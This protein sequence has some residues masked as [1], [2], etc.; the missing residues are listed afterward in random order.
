MDQD[1]SE[2]ILS[3]E[4]LYQQVWTTAMRKLAPRYGLSD[5]AL[6]K[7]CKKYKIPRPPAGYWAKIKH[8]HRPKQTPLPACNDTALQTVTIRMHPASGH[9]A[10]HG[11][12]TMDA[13][14]GKERSAFHIAVLHE[15]IDPH[16]LVKKTQKSLL[17][18]RAGYDGLVSPRA[19]DALNIRV[20]P[21]S[22]GRAMRIMD[23]F[24]K[25]CVAHGFTVSA[26]HDHTHKDITVHVN[27]ADVK[28]SFAEKVNRV[29]RALTPKEELNKLRLPSLYDQP[30]HIKF[31][32]GRL[33]MKITTW[34]RRGFRRQWTDG[35]KQRLEN[36]L[37]SLF[38]S[39]LK[40]SEEIKENRRKA[41]EAARRREAFERERAAKLS[42][43]H[44]E[45]E[46]VK[47]LEAEVGAWHRSE[48]I[49]RYVEVVNKAALRA[50]GTIEEGS[51][52]HNWMLWAI[53][54][55]DRFDPLV[56][57]PPSILDEKDKWNTWYLP[58]QTRHF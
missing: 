19:T 43:I 51:D 27:G 25:A 34:S 15:L 7:I 42:L 49:R 21:K 5:V 23:A 11:P 6:A 56:K 18:A 20:S 33:S 30:R 48:R 24:L 22:V 40:I 28:I 58:C 4:A 31:P 39:L 37:N 46:R 41:E 16:P 47:Q 55:A 1:K 10:S 26:G 32:S 8:G 35:K 57:S 2:V 17:A 52:L 45:E 54:Q 53:E 36:C 29:E 13:T 9:G 3:R 38:V 50:H 14:E 12:K 44:E